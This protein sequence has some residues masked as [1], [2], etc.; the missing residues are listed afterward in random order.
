MFESQFDEHMSVH[1][2]DNRY[3]CHKKGCKKD[4]DS[5]RARNYHERQHNAEAFYCNYREDPKAEK[6]NE[7]FYSK[8]HL[9][10]HYR[11]THGEG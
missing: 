4:Y 8:Q 3:I 7:K 10:Q 6:C 9:E 11:G 2:R 5:T 1:T